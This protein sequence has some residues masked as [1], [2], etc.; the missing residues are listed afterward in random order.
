MDNDQSGTLVTRQR[1]GELERAA[2]AFREVRRV[3]N[4]L[5]RQHEATPLKVMIADITRRIK[6]SRVWKSLSL[7]A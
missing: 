7:V 3:K 1:A 6:I 2:G 5:N 4:D